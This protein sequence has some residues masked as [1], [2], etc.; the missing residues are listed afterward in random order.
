MAIS[1]ANFSYAVMLMYLALPF[2]ALSNHFSAGNG[3]VKLF[4]NI[5]TVIKTLPLSGPDADLTVGQLKERIGTEIE[6]DPKCLVFASFGLSKPDD[7]VLNAYP[8]NGDDVIPIFVHLRLM[9]YKDRECER[10]IEAFENLAPELEDP[11]QS[12]YGTVKLL[13]TRTNRWMNSGAVMKTLALSGTDSD[14]TAGQLKRR[15]GAKINI[16][17]GCLVFISFGDIMLDDDVLNSCDRTGDDLIPIYVQL[18]RLLNYDP[19]EC[20]RY[21]ATFNNLAPGF[22]DPLQSETM[23]RVLTSIRTTIRHRTNRSRSLLPKTAR[24]P[25]SIRTTIMCRANLSNSLLPKSPRVLTSIRTTIR[26]RA[27]RSKPLLSKSPRV[28]TSIRT[29]IMHR[30]NRSKSLLAKTRVLTSIRTTIT[31]RLSPI[32]GTMD[33]SEL[34]LSKIKTHHSS[35]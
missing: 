23:T 12:G 32:I 6:I 29:T 4:S 1:F 2:A 20:S 30:T 33:R 35:I 24:L 16:D 21:N 25:S 28:L 11:L 8:R 26:C 7:D 10:F 17:P 3:T 13:Y 18:M 22:E 14:L 15:I 31:T 27:N 34:I 5:E 9:W 19:L